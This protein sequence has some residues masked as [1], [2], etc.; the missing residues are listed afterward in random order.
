MP[1]Q[2]PSFERRIP[3]WKI[4]DVLMQYAAEGRIFPIRMELT[5]GDDK[6][7]GLP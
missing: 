2:I 4:D 5:I 6:E 7:P 3:I 1:N